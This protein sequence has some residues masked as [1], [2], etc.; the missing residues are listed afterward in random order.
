M[1]AKSTNL[2]GEGGACTPCLTKFY[3]WQGI[4]KGRKGTELA[5]NVFLE[6]QK[7]KTFS[8]APYPAQ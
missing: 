8:L 6:Q 3:Q 7:K 2:L 1:K 5:D 4:N